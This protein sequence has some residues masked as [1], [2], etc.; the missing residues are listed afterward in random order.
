MEN[1]SIFEQDSSFTEAAMETT[2]TKLASLDILSV[3]VAELFN[4]DECAA[5][6]EGCLDDLW[7]QSRIVGNKDLHSS[8]R[9]KIR[10][11]ADGFPFDNIRSITKQANDEIYDFRLLGIIDQDFP[12]VFKYAEGDSYDWHMD[13]T[14]M[15]STRKISFLINLDDENSY[16]GGELH[17]LNTDT[18]N[19]NLNTKGSIVIFPSFITW[20]IDP[21]TKGEKNIILGHI[22]GAIFR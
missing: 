6:L 4:E 20:K 16:E 11:E 19:I 9:Q 17:F 5:I 8:K 1:E 3:N 18:S 7:I 2:S 15:A 10:G 12:Q 21:V 14:P 13:I 22:H